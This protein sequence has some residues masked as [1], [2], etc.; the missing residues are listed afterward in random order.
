MK[1]RHALDTFMG[2]FILATLFAL[3]ALEE[4]SHGR[5]R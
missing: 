1:I 3:E 5:K 2:T 4:L